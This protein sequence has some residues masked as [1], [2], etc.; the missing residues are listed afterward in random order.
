MTL[1][2]NALFARGVKAVVVTLG[3]NGCCLFRANESALHV[4]GHAMKV[5]DTI[6]AGD[7]FTGA[8]AAALTRQT[9]WHDALSWANAAAALST[10][11]QGAVSAMPTLKEV[12]TWLPHGSP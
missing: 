12:A 9:P 6:G 3:A 10:Q 8:L 1:A 2:A 7:T 11:A 4:P 5:V